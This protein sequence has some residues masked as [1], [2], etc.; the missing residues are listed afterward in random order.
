MGRFDDRATQPTRGMSDVLRWQWERVRAPKPAQKDEPAP[1]RAPDLA[2]MQSSAA[3]LTWIGHATF[4]L[5][6]AGK[7]V[8]T[9]PVWSRAL[10]GVAK[11]LVEP[12]VAIDR[13]PAVDV[14]VISHNHRD[15]MDLPTLAKLGDK[16]L[17]LVPLGNGDVVA[18]ATGA[19][20]VELDW[21]QAH[22][23]DGLTITLT[24]ARHWS[25]RFLFDRND[26]LWGGFVVRGPE[27]AAYHSGDTAFFDTFSE[28]GKRCGPIDWALLPIGAYEPRWFMESQHMNP[29]DA[30]KAF[31]LL[32]ARIFVAM[33]WGTFKLTDEPTG[34]P[35]RVL[36]SWWSSRGLDASRLWVPDVGETRALT[37]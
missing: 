9:D 5:R 14:V 20:V 4:A 37:A 6:L 2:L 31:E 33:H 35:P 7:L 1:K 3:S 13:M 10:S 36:R 29:S 24:P 23:H 17:Y 26:A 11:R 25:S 27:G 32:G 21:W 15:H 30:G 22:E 12:G 28:I 34:E 16:P 19:R 18:K 8:V